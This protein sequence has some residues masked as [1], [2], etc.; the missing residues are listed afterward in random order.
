MLQLKSP[1]GRNELPSGSIRENRMNTRRLQNPGRYCKRLF[2]GVLSGAR[3]AVIATLAIANTAA[4]ATAANEDGA[5]VWVEAND[6]SLVELYMKLHQSPEL[7]LEEEQ[8]AQR[9]A[10]ELRAVG[11]KVTTGVGGHGVVGVLE[12][13]PGKVLLVRTDLDALPVA[14]ETGIPY[15]SKVRAKDS[16]GGT[17]GVMH[18][19]GHDMHITN[20][21]GV[22]RYLA[23]HR[24]EWSGTVVFIGQPAEEIGAGA[25]AMLDDGL[26][27]RFPRPDYAVALHLAS[28][29]PTGKVIYCPGF[30]Q[31]NV[32]SVDITV[33]GRGGHGAHPETTIDPIV[34][35]AKLVVD[36]QTIVSRELDSNEPGVITVGSIH[37]GTKHNIIGDDCMLQ[38]TVRS[39]APEVREKLLA[40]IRRKA[41]AAAASA[42]AP[43]PIVEVSEGTPA[44]YNDPELME[45]VV[46]A[47]KKTLGDENVSLTEPTMGGEDFS[48]YGLAGVPICMFK[49][50]SVN[51]S[52][53]DEFT[54]RKETPPSLHSPKFYPDPA[55][56]LHAGVRAMVAAVKE[57]LP[58]ASKSSAG[59]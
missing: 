49:L 19:C 15:A 46:A 10:D 54:S 18:A 45:R 13:G 23:S 1:S 34:I 51:Q 16:R 32:D 53:L 38:I 2:G 40:A 37:G 59:E 36:L 57:L 9:L 11:A 28:D 26:F 22:A 52:R 4:I 31:A 8:T 14:E 20:L 55:E 44:L 12:N 30:S 56:T 3:C 41:S 6:E 21:V 47:I 7:S 5:K 25:R 29:V 48:Q 17:V 33:K 24:D 42:G 39:F 35:A 27:A 58:P 43:E 50:G